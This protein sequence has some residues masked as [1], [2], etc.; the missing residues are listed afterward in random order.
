[1]V[2]GPQAGASPEPY[3]SLFH[4][5]VLRALDSVNRNWQGEATLSSEERERAWHVLG[6]GLKLPVAWPSARTLLIRLALPMERDG[7][8]HE[9]LPLLTAGVESSRR[10]QDAAAEALLS[11]YVGRIHR[12]RGELE[13]AQAWFQASIDRYLTVNDTQGFATALNQL[14]YV[15]YLQGRFGDAKKRAEEALSLLE[16]AAAERAVS[17]FVLGRVAQEDRE[18]ASAEEFQ[19]TALQIWREAGNIQRTAWSLFNLGDT[20]RVAGRY[21]EAA[22]YIYEAIVLLGEL[23]DPVNQAVARMN[24]GIVASLQGK[25]DEAMALYH[26]AENIFRQVYDTLHLAMVY[27]NMAYEARVLAQWQLAEQHSQASIRLWETLG[28][29]HSLVSPLI[30]LGLTYL[31]QERYEEAIA[32]FERG[33]SE[34]PAAAPGGALDGASDEMRQMLE[35]HL[36]QAKEEAKEKGRL[37]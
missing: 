30:E 27:N 10:E 35:K 20:L 31:A 34:L 8:R 17:F 29:N 15:A 32:A 5:Y 9:W 12:L 1:M 14:A 37:S 21:D 36:A 18:L 11:L 13:Q 26:L 7:F 23:H 33:L 24:L 22:G 25:S 6:Y 2:S 4:E 3:L 28:A 16:A 19:R